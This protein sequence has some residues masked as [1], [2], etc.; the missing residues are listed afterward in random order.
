[1]RVL[2]ELRADGRQELSFLLVGA[3]TRKCTETNQLLVDGAEGHLSHSGCS[4]SRSPRRHTYLYRSV[5]PHELQQRFL[6]VSQQLGEE[7]QDL[8]GHPRRILRR[9]SSVQNTQ[10][11]TAVKLRPVPAH[12]ESAQPHHSWRLLVENLHLQDMESDIKDSH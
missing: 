5:D 10:F 9:K 2:L 7:E 3:G 8:L 11:H 6:H 4:C 12:L 1:M